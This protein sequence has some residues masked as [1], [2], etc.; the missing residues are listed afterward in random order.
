MNSLRCLSTL[1]LAYFWLFAVDI[2]GVMDVRCSHTFDWIVIFNKVSRNNITD[3][4]SP[5]H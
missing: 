2:V 4:V 3:L 5:G 1:S